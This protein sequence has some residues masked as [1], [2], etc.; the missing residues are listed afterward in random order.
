MTVTEPHHRAL[1]PPEVDERRPLRAIGAW[2]LGGS[3]LWWIAAAA[4]IP[5]D[6][7]FL[8]ETARD[9]S[10]SIAN[11]EGLFRAFHVVAGAG[12]VAAGVGIVLLGR[13]LRARRSSRI[14]DV[15]VLFVGV[16]TVAW[17]VE[18]A[19]RLTV[20]IDR[21]REV[22]AGQRSPGDEPAV[23][24]VPLFLAAWLAFVAPM[25]CSWVLARR[26]LPSRRGSIVGSVVATLA[27]LAATATMAPSVVYQFAVLTM[28]VVILLASRTGERVG[29]ASG[30]PA[31]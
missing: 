22:A 5:S 15:A 3:L 10:L 6:D 4:L 27:T 17:L 29:R 24:S 12:V 20:G 2:L 8:G 19:V 18:I 31:R 21:A 1:R 23:G 16:G 25:L 28:A 14:L 30:V 26:R 7:F 11:H 13:W 9:E